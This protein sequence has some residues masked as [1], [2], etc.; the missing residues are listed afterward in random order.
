MFYSYKSR[1]QAISEAV[2][3]GPNSHLE[4]PGEKNLLDI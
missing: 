2:V 4:S 3:E 1:T